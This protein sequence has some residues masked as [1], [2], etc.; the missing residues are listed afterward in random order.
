MQAVA[1][2]LSRHARSGGTI[3]VG[4][5]GGLD[6]TVLLHASNRHAADAGLSLFALHVHHGLSP[7]ADAWAD[8]CERVCEQLGI[9]LIVR[10][11]AVPAKSGDGIEAYAVAQIPPPK[12]PGRSKVPPTVPQI[13]SM[14]MADLKGL[15]R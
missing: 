8:S 2:C 10:R 4:Y 14:I 15:V 6:S 1:A 3:A 5:S 12:K 13:T 9:P 11:V 7:N